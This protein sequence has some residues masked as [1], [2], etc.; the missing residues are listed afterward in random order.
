MG[1]CTGRYRGA[2]RATKSK[3]VTNA[4]EGDPGA[5]SLNESFRIFHRLPLE[6]LIL[7]LEKALLPLKIA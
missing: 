6:L 7:A 1:E 3:E 4:E 2:G 5:G